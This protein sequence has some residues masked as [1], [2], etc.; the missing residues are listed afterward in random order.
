[1]EY[2]ETRARVPLD[3]EKHRAQKSVNRDVRL[4]PSPF[5]YEIR[6]S[7]HEEGYRP[8]AFTSEPSIHP[9][10]TSGGWRPSGSFSVS[11]INDDTPGKKMQPWNRRMVLNDWSDQDYAM[12][13]Y[14]DPTHASRFYRSGLPKL[15]GA[16]VQEFAE[17][18]EAGSED[19][20]GR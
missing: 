13:C 8:G 17:G 5:S 15:G 11:V 12:G 18:V 6:D 20:S 3:D 14:T 19:P 10:I 7:T 16:V 9:D 1:M 4:H 2:R